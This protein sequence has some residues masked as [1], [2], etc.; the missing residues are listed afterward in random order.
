MLQSEAQ[1]NFWTR[2]SLPGWLARRPGKLSP[3]TETAQCP[4]NL[5][6]SL[7]SRKPAGQTHTQQSPSAHFHRVIKRDRPTSPS[8]QPQSQPYSLR[9]KTA[10][11][12]RSASVPGPQSGTGKGAPPAARAGAQRRRGHAARAGSSSARP[13]V[14]GGRCRTTARP[15][16]ERE[17]GLC[18]ILSRHCAPC[19]VLRGPAASPGCG[20]RADG[21]RVG[22]RGRYQR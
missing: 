17:I 9:R 12:T 15:P 20:G 8:A 19:S 18:C 16:P 2:T 1:D 4:V 21:P 11:T 13:G 7:S 10:L 5:A 14:A 22:L 3:T 6:A